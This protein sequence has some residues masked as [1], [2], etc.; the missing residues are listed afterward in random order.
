MKIASIDEIR[1]LDNRAIIEY[2]ISE[3]LL[4]ENAG[5]AAYTVIKALSSVESKHFV[6]FAGTGN[7]GGDGFVV[8]R[9]LSS[10]GGNV[11]IFILGDVNKI[12]GVS[13]LNLDRL[14]NFPV[15]VYEVRAVNRILENSLLEANCVIDS[16]FGVG[17]SHEITGLYKEVINEIN[18]S[19]KTVVSIDI[20]SGINGDTGE[21]MGTAVKANYTVTFGLPK[22]GQFQYPGAEFVGKLFVSHV[23]YPPQLFETEEIKVELNIPENLPER[24]RDFHKGD[25]GKALFIAGSKSYLGAPFF[26]SYSFLKGGGGVSYLATPES[27]A[28]ISTTEA[29]EVVLLPL[30]ETSEGTISRVNLQF[31]LDFAKNMDVVVI[32]PGISLNVETK[33]LFYAFVKGVEKP[34]LIDG[35][36]LTLLADN[37]DIIATKNSPLILTPHLG[38]FSRITRLETKEIK[39][40]KFEILSEYSQKLNATIVLKGAFTLIAKNDGRILINPSGNPGMATAGSGDVLTGLIAAM[41]GI[42]FSAKKAADIGVF[43]HGF[44]GDLKAKEIGEDGL[45]A[46]DIMEGIPYAIKRIREQY[47]EIKENN[48]ERARA[49]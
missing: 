7:N 22:R 32:G 46:R 44:A 20:P 26:S 38:E 49:V 47:E 17:L 5:N 33:E 19:N 35:D 21:V 18:L 25:F 41:I 31:L 13:R 11:S 36:G 6:V 30:K 23:S 10:E 39:S 9:K 28:N 4:M 15:E 45:T 27:I 12:T 8:S 3:E 29:R 2:G 48:Y 37:Q 14:K 24:R 16:I 1:K 34:L 42:G 40:R 43:I